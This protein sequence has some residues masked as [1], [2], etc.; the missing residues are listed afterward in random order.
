[1][2]QGIPYC[3]PCGEFHDELNCQ[4]F[5]QIC[6]EEPYDSENEQIN[7]CGQE[8]PVSREEWIEMMEQSSRV[9]YVNDQVDKVT[10]VYGQKPTQ[11]KILEMTRHK[12]ITYQRRGKQNQ[13]KTQ[14][15]IPK[16]PS[17]LKENGPSNK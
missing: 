11:G 9:N 12:G 15:S 16:V 17:P 14:E 6:K 5:L 4:V 1:M 8:Y 13:E 10:K 7:M 3:R 2:Y